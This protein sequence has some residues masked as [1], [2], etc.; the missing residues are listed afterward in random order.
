MKRFHLS[1]VSAGLALAIMSAPLAVAQQYQNHGDTHGNMQGHGSMQHTTV[2][3]IT[4]EHTTMQ[5]STMQH[6]QMG[7]NE[8]APQHGMMSQHYQ[9][10]MHMQQP[11][12]HQAAYSGHT[13]HNTDH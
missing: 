10:P 9:A 8:M 2:R 11:Q 1:T 6:E 5:H 7:H 4:V 13:G 12:N 3:H